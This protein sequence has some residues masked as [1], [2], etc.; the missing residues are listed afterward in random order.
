MYGVKPAPDEASDCGGAPTLLVTGASVGG[1][2]VAGRVVT[3]GVAVGVGGTAGGGTCAGGVGC[4][5]FNSGNRSTGSAAAAADATA[6]VRPNA[7]ISRRCM[8]RSLSA[9][10]TGDRDTSVRSASP[11]DR[12]NV[13]SPKRRQIWR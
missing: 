9:I 4:A 12:V 13:E 11:R 6:T 3:P 1:A 5:W 2:V 8:G 7:A 10:G